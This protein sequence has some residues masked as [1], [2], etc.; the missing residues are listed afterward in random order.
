MLSVTSPPPV[1]VRRNYFL[2]GVDGKPSFVVPG[3][4]LCAI[5]GSHLAGEGCHDAVIAANDERQ[6]VDDVVDQHQGLALTVHQPPHG[7]EG[8]SPSF[9]TKL[10]PLMNTK[11]KPLMNNDKSPNDFL[12]KIAKFRQGVTPGVTM[13]VA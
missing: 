9:P 4:H 7:F 11:L 12:S 6:V 3:A 5:F 2:R 8:S 1:L 13:P 10:K